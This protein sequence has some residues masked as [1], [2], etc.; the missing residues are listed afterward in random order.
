MKK[1]TLFLLICIITFSCKE[2][3]INIEYQ[4]SDKPDLFHCSGVDMD[5]IKEAVYSFEK[6]ILP[7]LETRRAGTLPRAYNVTVNL[8]INKHLN[9][10]EIA[11]DH[12]KKIFMILKTKKELWDTSKS[13]HTLNYNSEFVNCAIDNFISND[14]KETTKALISIDAMNE[15]SFNPPLLD[16]YK[17]IYKDNGLRAFL[18][19]EYFY[20]HFFKTN[21]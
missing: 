5:L 1:T 16:N 7:Y 13:K 15:N 12:T 4:F 14:L 18:A 8:S 20:S 2:K 9:I 19:L 6:D 21:N 10:N 17:T 11:S 3:T